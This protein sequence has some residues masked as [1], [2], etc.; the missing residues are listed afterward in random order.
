VRHLILFLKERTMI[1]KTMQ[2]A[3]NKHIQA[4]MYSANLYLAMSAYCDSVN[5]KGFA[6]W[7][8]VQYGEEMQHAFKLFDYLMERGGRALVPAIEAPPKEFK[9]PRNVFDLT[10][11]HEKE[12]SEKVNKLYELALKEKDYA[13]QILLQWFITEQVEEEA[14]ASEWVE[15]MKLIG[16]SSNAIWWIDKELRK[17]QG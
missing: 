5:M 7:M 11:A 2:D 10:L 12:I 9:S 15:K 6:S 16:E 14:R 13:S 3:I 17:R 1:S 4:E 8:R